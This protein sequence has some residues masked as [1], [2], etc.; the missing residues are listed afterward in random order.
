MPK[1]N[2]GISVDGG[3]VAGM[4]FMLK[5]VFISYLI[6]VALLFFMALFATYRAMSDTGISVLANVVTALGTLFSGFAAGRHFSGKGIL[7]GAASGILYTVLLCIAGNIVSGRINLGIPVITA[8]LI[9]LICGAVGGISGINT[10]H[11]R[12][13]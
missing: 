4:L 1:S 12:R 3:F 9:G 10:R 6:S 13:R 5:T 11:T 2:Q 7:Y 8:I